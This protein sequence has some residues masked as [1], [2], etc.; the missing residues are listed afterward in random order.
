MRKQ[1]MNINYSKYDLT[2]EEVEI[3]K[4][5]IAREEALKKKSKKGFPL[6]KILSLI[7]VILFC[8]FCKFVFLRSTFFFP[9]IKNNSCLR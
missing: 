8:S 3:L 4:E 1:K 5:E 7:L 9:S 6:T 2:P